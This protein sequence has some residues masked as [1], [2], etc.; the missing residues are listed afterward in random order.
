M[1][2]E[3]FRFKSLN[4]TKLPPN[5]IEIILSA[6][7]GVNTVMVDMMDN[8]VTVDYDDLKTTSAEIRSKLEENKLV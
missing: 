7:N 2:K 5:N 8:T 1:Q 4:N 3:S 6:L